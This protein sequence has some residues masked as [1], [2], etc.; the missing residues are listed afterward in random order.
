MQVI[1]SVH[2]RV[3]RVLQCAGL[4]RAVTYSCIHRL[5]VFLD[6][7]FQREV[8]TQQLA[9]TR[10]TC[11]GQVFPFESN[12]NAPGHSGFQDSSVLP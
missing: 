1:T 10:P 5:K 6:V 3:A 12:A 2:W 9:V 8:S 7:E 11:K 4:D